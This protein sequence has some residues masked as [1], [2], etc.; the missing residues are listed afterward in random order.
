MRQVLEK[1]QVPLPHELGFNA[2]DNPY[3]SEGFFKLCKD[4]GVPQDPMRYWNERF[5]WTYQCG[6]KWPNDYIGPDSMT[7]WII[8][9]SQGF[10]NIGS[11]RLSESISSNPKFTNLCEVAYCRQYGESTYCPESLFK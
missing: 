8:K 1:L 3:S 2:T 5:Y 10:I 7:D 9:K 4:Y 11:Y 6:V